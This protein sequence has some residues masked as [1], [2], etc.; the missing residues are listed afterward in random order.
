[1]RRLVLALAT[2][3]AGLPAH[4]QNVASTP[5]S[6]CV[7]SDVAIKGGLFVTGVANLRFSDG[8]TGQFTAFCPLARFNSG[9]TS[10]NLKLTYQDST[11]TATGPRGPRPACAGSSS[12]SVSR[13]SATSC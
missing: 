1:M 11:G 10:W 2:L 5:A 6:A 7:P 4:A 13:P 12:G 3:F 9:T 8:A